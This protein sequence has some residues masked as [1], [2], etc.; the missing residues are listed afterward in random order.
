MIDLAI[1]GGGPGGYVAAERAGAKGLSVILFEK[2]ELG[3]VCL[4]EGCIPTKT[5]LYSA[6][7]FDYAKHGDKY[8][9]NVAD[10]TFDFGKI[11]ARKDKV[12]KKLVAGVGSKMKA[13]KITVV[14]GEALIRGRSSEGI[15]ISCNGEPYQARNLLICTGSETFIPPIPGVREAGD[16]IVTNREILSLREQPKSLVIIGGGVIGMEFASFYNGLGTEVTV[17][18]MLPEILGGLDGEISRMLREIYT[19]KGIRFNLSCKVTEIK[20]TEVVHVNPEGVRSSAKGEKILMSVGR[21]AVTQGFG[22]ENLG[23]ETDRNA[24]RVDSKMRTNIPNV[25]AAG[26]VTGFSMLAHTASREGEVV[27]NNLTG[28]PDIMRYN[29]IPGIVYTNPEVAG[30][31]LTEEQAKKEGIAYKIAKLP[32]AYAGRFVAENEGGSGICKVLAGE[33]YGEILGV[34]LLGNPCSEIIY[35]ACMAIEQ[36]MTL[37]EMEE[38]VFPHPTVSEIFKETVFAL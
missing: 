3:G 7:I 6:K 4:N 23:V 27:V 30:V 31:G 2:R 11:I 1:I 8:G 25:F 21:R 19:K 16:T 15:E 9:I 33:K 24:I 22:L 5:L 36:E 18:E 38:V 32:M 26:D 20:G 35:G 37:K 28:R 17:V 10:A 12:V 34:H 29:A 14:R 13:H